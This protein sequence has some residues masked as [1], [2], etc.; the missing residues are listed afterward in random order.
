MQNLWTLRRLASLCFLT[1]CSLCLCGVSSYAA[2]PSLGNITPRGGQRGTEMGLLFNGARLSDAQ[3]IFI[4]YPGI[5]VAKLEVVNDNQVKVTVKIAP[6]CRLGEH[7][8]RVRTASGISELRTLYVGAMPIIDEKE[9]NNEITAPQKLPPLPPPSQGGAGGVTIHGVVESEGLDYYLF[10]AKKGQRVTAE[11]EGMRLGDALFDPYVAILD[12]KRFELATSDDSAL[13]GQDAVASV[14]IPEDGTYV[15]QVRDS[16]YTGSGG[17][18]L[19]VGTFPRPTATLPAGGKLGEEVEVRFLGDPAGELVQKIKLPATPDPTFGLFAQDAGGI[20]PSPNAFRLCEF[21]NVIEAEPNDN[22]QQATKAEQLPIALNGVIA[23]PGDVDHFRFTAKKGQT[24]DIHCYARRIRSPLDPVMVIYHFGGAAIASNDDTSGPDS[25]IRFTAPE[26]KEYAVSVTD[27]L[28]KG[29][30]NYAYRIEFTPVQPKLTV[31]VPKVDIFGYSQERQTIPVP[32]GNRYATLVTANRVDF[33][34]D[35]VLGA[36]GL[37]AGL[38]MHA[39]TMPAAVNVTPVVFEAAPDAPVAGKLANLVARHADPNQKISGDFVQDVMLVA[40]GNV[41]IFWKH[42]TDRAAVAVTQEV[43]FKIS[44]VESKAP[45]VQNGS[46]SLK[47]VAERKNGFKAPITLQML[48]NP[49]GVGS[50][51]SVTIPEGQNEAVYPINANSGAMVRKWKIAILGQATVGNG[52]VYVSSQLAT[53][54]VAPPFVQFALERAAVEQGKETDLFCKIQHSTPFEGPAKVRL[55]GLPHMVTA[56][57]ADITKDTKELAF[58]IKTD[59]ASPA[60]QHKN[61]FCQVVVTHNGEPVLHN[62][63]SGELRI[64]VP[65]PPKP[66]QPPPGPMPVAQKPPEPQKPPEK[67]LTRLEKLRLEQ[68]EKEKAAKPP[69][70]EKKP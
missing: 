3:E 16:A 69:E 56:P 18:R 21:G 31:S 46:M 50:A 11:I 51:S 33:G 59:K 35:L 66:N 15:V 5:T 42:A 67:R 41:G 29:A 38:T 62:V 20:A 48:F 60:G 25:Y 70:P 49:P 23:K 39:D 64:D 43:P 63:G 34:G 9:P 8:M 28:G 12:M 13:L 53:L 61:L 37:P 44:I 55:I 54:E 68:Q 26:D 58:K 30:A 45:L 10:E 22:H 52:P 19:H 57:E 27:H 32:R 14:I 2:S 36:E 47:V 17:Y 24:Y 4:Y 1:L 40:V 65:P 6:D 7:A